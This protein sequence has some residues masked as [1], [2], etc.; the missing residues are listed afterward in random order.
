[1]FKLLT[2]ISW[3]LTFTTRP[4]VPS[5]KVAK[6][7]SVKDDQKRNKKKKRKKERDL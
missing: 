2:Y 5:P 7:L 3:S 1:M 4:K 6:I